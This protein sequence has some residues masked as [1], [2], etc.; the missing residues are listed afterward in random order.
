MSYTSR[1]PYGSPAA[2]YQQAPESRATGLAANTLADS[3]AQVGG[4]FARVWG[5]QAQAQAVNDAAGRSSQ[6][7]ME[8]DDLVRGFDVDPEPGTVPE[9]AKI[10]LAEWQA[11]A[12]EAAPPETRSFLQ[13]NLASIGAVAYRQIA[14]AATRRTTEGLVGRLSDTLSTEAQTLA[15]AADEPATLASVERM[16]QAIAG[17]ER[18]G[19]I[20]PGRATALFSRGVRQAIT[21]R[22][23]ADPVAAQAMLD[24][25]RGEMDAAD[26]AA[27]ATSL[28][29]PV[30]GRQDETAAER[31][32]RAVGGA[33][34]IASAIEAQESGG[35]DGLVSIDGA[36]GRMQIMPG[37]W[38]QY[39]QPGEQI[40]NP[41]H[42]RAVGQRII[43]D[44]SARFGGDPARIAVAYFSGPGNVA[45]PGSPT[46][47]KEDRRDGNGMTVSRYVQ[48]VLARMAPP[49]TTTQQRD[50]ALAETRREAEA[51]GLPLHR[52]LG[53]E[54]RV[55]QYFAQ[56]QA[57]QGH[58]R[59][60]LAQEVR[61]LGAA[62]QG[63]QTTA[64]IPEARIREVLPPEQA[65]RSIDELQLARATGQ[66][67]QAV[68]AA[69]PA[70]EA[71]MRARLAGDGAATYMAGER[72][73]NVQRFD[74]A[75]AE[76]RR[77]LASDPHAYAMAADPQLR[78]LAEAEAPV[79]QLATA[80]IEAQRRMGVPEG[81]LRILSNASV[82]R[83][84]ETLRI[85]GPE[86][87]DLAPRLAAL[88]QEFGP[89]WGRAYGELVQHGKVPWPVQALAGMTLPQ[90]AEGRAVLQSTLKLIAERGPEALDKLIPK[91]NRL[92]LPDAVADAM[93]PFAQAT[94]YHPGGNALEATMR[95]AVETLAKGYASNLVPAADAAKRAYNDV[96]GARWDTAGDDGSGWFENGPTLLVPK[97]EAGRIETALDQVRGAIKPA[98]LAPLADPLNPG[99][100]EQQLRDATLKAAQRGIW[101]NNAD[102][103]GAVLKGRTPGGQI[104]DIL[105]SEGRPIEVRFGELPAP[106][107]PAAAPTPQDR[108]RRASPIAPMMVPR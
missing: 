102:A 70:E 42:N 63:G 11:E 4:Q 58:E 90:Q 103:S 29:A 82:E 46:P 89:L 93:K 30:E 96:I 33:P 100:T 79:Q 45:P 21:L 60:A 50:M 74:R 85:T 62:Y 39:A 64:E 66:A 53:R 49:G 35:R 67:V 26:V 73:Q 38:A 98:D 16:K 80:S 23:A 84:A 43:A 25:F 94:R 19:V 47:W 14:G 37:T 101:I 27:L 105:D 104:I 22:A 56:A 3:L 52:V 78:A 17:N 28:R 18:A 6:L 8:A 61:D 1:T 86:T 54:A 24:R 7:A 95:A 65:Q 108:A 97:G 88:A 87:A 81:K 48:Q 59:A 72:Q 10:K 91:A 15:G 55:S 69:S 68:A 57:A 5:A 32:I 36:R 99:A 77:A 107:P 51:E 76:K 83:M 75:I 20:P 12:L 44:L 9:R 41:E 40:D 2:P 34:D 13:R 31:R 71:E 92:V 106:P